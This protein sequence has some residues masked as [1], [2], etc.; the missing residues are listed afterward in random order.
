MAPKQ[1]I[2]IQLELEHAVGGVENVK[3]EKGWIHELMF[4]FRNV[5]I[6]GW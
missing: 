4:Q 2:T 1:R 6:Q 5:E 3:S